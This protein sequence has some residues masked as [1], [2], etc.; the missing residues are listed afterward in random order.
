MRGRNAAHFLYL[1]KNHVPMRKI[2]YFPLSPYPVKYLGW[3]MT[4]AGVILFLFLHPDYQL[5]LYAGLLL[6]AYSRE[7]KETEYIAQVR[8]EAFK[9]V[10]GFMLSLTIAVHLTEVLSSGFEADL[11]LFYYAGLPLLLYLLL[12]YGTLLLKAEVDSSLDVIQNLKQH[13]RLYTWWLLVSILVTLVLVFRW[14]RLI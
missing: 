14:A 6:V 8:A 9:S 5:L 1:Q 2:T 11:P 7:R 3:L 10:F 12:F 13:R 4:L